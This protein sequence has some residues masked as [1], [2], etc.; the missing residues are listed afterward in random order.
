MP[1]QITMPSAPILENMN[2]FCRLVVT[3]TLYELR[4]VK[5]PME[6]MKLVFF[7]N[8]SIRVPYK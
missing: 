1:A 2:T 5:K 3:R 7:F 4:N 6:K 8:F